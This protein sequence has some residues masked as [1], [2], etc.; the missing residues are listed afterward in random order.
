MISRSEKQ[1]I[2][3]EYLHATGRNMLVPAEFLDW[4]RDQP[5]HPCYKL[6]FGKSQAEAAQAW[7]VDQVR[8]WVSGLRITVTVTT[9]Q[10]VNV[11]TVTMREVTL[12]AAFSDP[13]GHRAGGGYTPTDPDDPAHREALARE[14]GRSLQAWLDR[15][16]GTCHMLD[17][18]PTGVS[19]L[20]S[21]LQAVRAQTAEA[22]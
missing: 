11:G 3:N 18:D 6:F 21:A 15:H 17:L 16:A 10:R 19:T 8:H 9:P 20:A 2:V 13:S 1:R 5:D 12:P 22:A 7:R 14:A 4:L